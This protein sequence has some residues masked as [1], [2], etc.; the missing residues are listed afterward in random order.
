MLERLT[1][2]EPLTWFVKVT[3]VPL[4]VTANQR[5]AVSRHLLCA[6]MRYDNEFQRPEVR[7]SL[8]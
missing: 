2:I 1:K 3:A 7:V 8:R 5:V 4:V 6:V